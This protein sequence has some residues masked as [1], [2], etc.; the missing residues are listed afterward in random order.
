MKLNK[1]VKI[2]TRKDRNNNPIKWDFITT[3]T[4][5]S[6]Y[7]RFSRKFGGKLKWFRYNPEHIVNLLKTNSKTRKDK[8][9]HECLNTLMTG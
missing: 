8:S 5:K 4:S 6:I 9:K 1:K 3:N 7:N 2:Q